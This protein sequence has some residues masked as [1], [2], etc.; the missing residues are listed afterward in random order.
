MP[1]PAVSAAFSVNRRTAHTDVTRLR[2]DFL[3]AGL[4]ETVCTVEHGR[5]P[6][7]G[8]PSGAAL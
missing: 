7:G 3:Q 2:A 6:A 1:L 8:A 5:A 4:V